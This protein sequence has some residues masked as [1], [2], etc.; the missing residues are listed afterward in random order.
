MPLTPPTLARTKF[1]AVLNSP[2]TFATPLV[3]LC[4]D[5][6]GTECFEW[7]PETLVLEINDDFRVTLP[8]TSLDR[9]LTGIN[10]IT[11]DSFYKSLPDF[12]TFCNIMSGDTYDPRTWDPADAA[13]I[14]WGI[15]EG[16]LLSPPEDDDENPFTEEIVAYIGAAIDRAGMI[17]PPDVLKIAVRDQDPAS[18]VQGEFSDDPMMFEAV[19]KLEGSKTEEINRLV[20]ENLQRLAQQLDSL[21]LRTGTTSGVVKTM[22]QQFGPSATASTATSKFAAAPAFAAAREEAVRRR[23]GKY[24]RMIDLD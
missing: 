2:E 15:T 16:L 9:L 17:H 22:L 5:T 6:Y 12:V 24:S 23:Y 19:Y 13:E 11:S 18:F 1:Q 14:A 10:L 20:R 7:Q 3:A 4:V 8:G 21:P